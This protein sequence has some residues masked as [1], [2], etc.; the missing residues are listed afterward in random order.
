MILLEFDYFMFLIIRN[1]LNNYDSHTYIDFYKV[2]KL[3]LLEYTLKPNGVRLFLTFRKFKRRNV[4]R[5]ICHRK[6]FTIYFVQ[7]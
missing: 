2:K 7:I 4:E 6:K 5:Q 3:L 1:F